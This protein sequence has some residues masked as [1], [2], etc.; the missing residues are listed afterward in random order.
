MVL[1][2]W[3]KK[4]SKLIMVWLK[5]LKKW[6]QMKRVF[7]NADDGGT[8]LLKSAILF[9]REKSSD[10]IGKPFFLFYFKQMYLWKLMKATLFEF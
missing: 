3:L 10:I 2:S 1:K 7:G 6:L 9:S 8:N 5:P 4:S